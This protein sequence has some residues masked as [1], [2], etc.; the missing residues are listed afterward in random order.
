M[1]DRTQVTTGTITHEK[2]HKGFS[3]VSKLVTL[4]DLERR[5]GRYSAF[6]CRLVDS[7]AN[8]VNLIESKPISIVPYICSRNVA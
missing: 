6:F 1:Q 4:N 3:F 8:Y 7:E 2:S 5:N